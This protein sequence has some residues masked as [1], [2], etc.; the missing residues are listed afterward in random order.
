MEYKKFGNKYIVRIDKGEEIVDTLKK[1]CV[2]NKIRLG[3]IT[4]LG[5]T[6]KVTIGLFETQSKKYFS[7]ELI[8]NHEI[9]PLYGNITTMNGEIYLHLHV[10]LGNEEHKS[11]AGHL[12]SAFVSATVEVIIDSIE[13]EVERNFSDEIGLNL[14]K[15]T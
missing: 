11:F 4:G 3:T 14:L 6:N 13:G 7:K 5:A 10:N 8:G 12:N 9:A 15:F 1:F 2:D